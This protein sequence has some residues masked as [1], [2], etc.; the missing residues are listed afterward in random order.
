MEKIYKSKFTLIELLVVIAIIAILAALLLPALNSA[1]DKAQEIYCASNMKQIFNMSMTF[2]SDLD[3]IMPASCNL[4]Y[5][6]G[7]NLNDPDGNGYPDN[8]PAD[9]WGYHHSIAHGGAYNHILIDMGY[10][11]K[12]ARCPID[13]SDPWGNMRKKLHGT[14]FMCPSMWTGLSN[15]EHDIRPGRIH[16][17]KND[18]DLR[19]SAYPGDWGR[20]TDGIQYKMWNGYTVN[21]EAG[22][23]GA[24]APYYHVYFMPDSPKK[25]NYGFYLRKKWRHA[26]VSKIG[27]L[28][29]NYTDSGLCVHLDSITRLYYS[30]HGFRPPVRH[31][32]FRT[33]NMI[34]Y[35]GHLG[36]LDGYKYQTGADVEKDFT[37][38]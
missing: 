37:L 23:G 35:D 33:T 7:L 28:F 24:N 25:V 32:K 9:Y 34:F 12:S 36:V 16:T 26:N 30:W 10:A 15:A 31:R 22:Q 11:P 14:V 21:A 18:L 4:D 27:Y 17:I 29:E 3:G 6:Q 38:D 1:R 19:R 8:I 20:G 2:G 5:L 13:T